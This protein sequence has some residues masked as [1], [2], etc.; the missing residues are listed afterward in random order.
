MFHKLT[1]NRKTQGFTLVELLVVI[2]I[3]AVLISIL[4]PSLNQ[5]RKAA[6]RV[7]CMSNLRQIGNAFALY[8]VDNKGWWPIAEH[9]WTET[10]ST[11]PNRDKRW[12][13][14]IG[15]YL[16]GSMRVVSP[17]GTVYQTN[18]LNYNGSAGGITTNS[19]FGT[20]MD[21]AHIGTVKDITN[22]IWGCEAWKR[23]TNSTGTI[24]VDNGVHP[25]YTM[26]FYPTSPS[27]YIGSLNNDFFSKRAFRNA[28]ADTIPMPASGRPG[29]YFRSSQW[30]KPADRALI[31]ESI[32]VNIQLQSSLIGGWVYLPETS[33]GQ[34]FPTQP[35]TVNLSLDFNRHGKRMIGNLPTDPSMNEL[36]CDGHVGFVSCRE[37]YR[38]I[39]FH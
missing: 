16:V 15:K 35:D 25:G 22:P 31:V 13:D 3:I 39:R 37:C 18:E 14:Y 38:S 30:N 28:A 21:P 26:Q 10:G 29:H 12:H 19:L 4:L 23:Y 11:F 27:D 6:V 34:V 5:A 33:G 20:T 2:G 1:S 24:L 17:G 7:K 9:L 8:N 32:H 36:Y